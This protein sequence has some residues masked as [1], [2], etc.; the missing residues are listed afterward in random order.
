MKYLIQKFF[1]KKKICCF[2]NNGKTL[3]WSLGPSIEWNV[4][5]V[6]SSWKSWQKERGN[7][8]SVLFLKFDLFVLSEQGSCVRGFPSFFSQLRSYRAASRRFQTELQKFSEFPVQ[9]WLP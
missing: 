9:R 5:F 7:S 8:L 2:Y 3:S 6:R 1:L 4:T